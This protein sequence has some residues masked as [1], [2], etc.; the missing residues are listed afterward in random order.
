MAGDRAAA[1][2]DAIDRAIPVVGEEHRSVLHH[3]QINRAADVA[4]VLQEAGDERLDRPDSALFSFTTTMSPPNLLD[5][6][7]EPWR[8]IKIA[9]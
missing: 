6:F 1:V 5:L 9:P 7:Q 8:A 2:G 3:M 4:V